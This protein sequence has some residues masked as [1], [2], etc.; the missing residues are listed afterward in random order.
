[1]TISLNPAHH[2][3]RR[4]ASWL[5]SIHPRMSLSKI[6]F[7]EGRLPISNWVPAQEDGGECPHL[8]L[9]T[10]SPNLVPN[11]HAFIKMKSTPRV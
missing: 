2:M 10:L 9:A 4:K 11:M 1:M 3:L 7:W 8:V 5:R 6:G